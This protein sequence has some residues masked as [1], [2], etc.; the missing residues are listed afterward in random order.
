MSLE[1]RVNASVQ[2]P[3]PVVRRGALRPRLEEIHG[4][5][6]HEV[7]AVLDAGRVSGAG[8]WV[9]WAAVRYLNDVFVKRLQ[10]TRGALDRLRPWCSDRAAARLWAVGELLEQ[11]RLQLERSV[12]L[13]QSADEFGTLAVK[14]LRAL[15]CW[16]RE[17]EE[18]LGPLE[19]ESL[20]RSGRVEID[21]LA[22]GEPIDGD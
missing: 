14:L 10:R 18:A 12:A 7:L 22:P 5:W 8:I 21:R 16:C 4:A 9:R 19:W 1:V 13:H 11:L 15:G 20:P 3:A 2:P 17:V 6:M